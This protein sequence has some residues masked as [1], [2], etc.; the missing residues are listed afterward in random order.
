MDQ[1]QKEGKRQF[2]LTCPIAV[3]QDAKKSEEGKNQ[4]IAGIIS[5]DEL[6]QQG[7]RIL[8]EGLCFDH[9]LNQRG[10]LNH[11]HGSSHHDILGIPED[12]RQFKKNDILPNGTAAK[13]N[14]SWVEGYLL[15]TE[16]GRKTYEMARALQGTDRS[17]GFSVEGSI[18]K[19]QGPGGKVIGKAK[20]KHVAIT[21]QPVNAS[22]N[23]EALVRSLS[24]LEKATTVAQAPAPQK[25]LV[26]QNLSHR[27][28]NLAS[29]SKK[30]TKKARKAQD[31]AIKAKNSHT[32]SKSLEY[33]FKAMPNA[34]VDYALWLAA[35]YDNI[36]PEA[37]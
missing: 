18:E 28:T 17:L 30:R 3:F 16:Q 14:C 27:L 34:S 1:R 13:A 26:R 23:L 29:S 35:I 22:T 2:R 25:D 36:F 24:E 32:T 8:Q 20:I 19:R 7:E 11:D 6:D 4:R 5:T 21:H 10:Y 37:P 15:D 12:V 9:L 31:C 33:V